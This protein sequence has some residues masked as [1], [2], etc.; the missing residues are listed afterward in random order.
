MI[1]AALRF[2]DSSLK[3]ENKIDL[4]HVLSF[5][6]LFAGMW[7]NYGT[8]SNRLTACEVQGE[9]FSANIKDLSQVLTSSRETMLVMQQQNVD[10]DKYF[11][12]LMAAQNLREDR[13]MVHATAGTK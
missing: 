12:E 10:R 13:R 11:Q 7:I 5:L 4:G 3:F 1:R 9:K 6:V 2:Q 8:F